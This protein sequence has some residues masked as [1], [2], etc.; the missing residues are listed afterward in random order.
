MRLTA[1]R[2]PVLAIVGCG[3]LIAASQVEPRFDVA[4]VKQVNAGQKNLSFGLVVHPGYF[5]YGSPSLDDLIRYAYGVNS[6]EQV[7][8]GPKW[9]HPAA[10]EGVRFAIE[11]TYP[12]H[13]DAAAVP[14]MVQGLLRDR[15]KLALHTVAIDAKVYTLRPG[16]G[17]NKL[18]PHAPGT[19]VYP[20]PCPPDI[21]FN[22]MRS[23]RAGPV[24]VII[25]L[26]S[27]YCAIAVTD[28]TNLTG[29]YSFSFCYP[30][31]LQL[32]QPGLPPPLPIQAAVQE[33]LG[34]RLVPGRGKIRKFVI[35]HAEMPLAN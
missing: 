22:S 16:N 35:D 6:Y 17:P 30:T 18:V 7:V 13:A 12:E 21:G 10:R 5:H 1:R 11:A 20:Q 28:E 2:T 14:A 8:G 3:C 25:A 4:S 32:A 19:P 9:A 26:F 29:E 23:Y 31:P 34:L 27:K 33:Q 15:F 24:A